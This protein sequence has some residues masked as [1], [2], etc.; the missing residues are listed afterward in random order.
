[1]P[2]QITNQA[3]WDA[4]VAQ[5]Q[6]P[7]QIMRSYTLGPGVVPRAGQT[8]AVVTTGI[9]QLTD[10]VKGILGQL[11]EVVA[12][13]PPI[14]G[15]LGWLAPVLGFLGL[16]GLAA[17]GAAAYGASQLAGVQYPWETGAGEGFIMPW[18]R[19]IVRDEA[20]QW[21]SS[22]TRPDLFGGGQAPLG[23]GQ[24]PLGPGGPTVVKSWDTG[25]TNA[26]G[27]RVAGWPFVMTSDGRI[28]T[29]KKNGIRVSYKPYKSV[30]LG[31][32]PSPRMLS[33]AVTKM[34]QF[35]KTHQKIQ[36]MARRIKT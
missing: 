14:G 16:G 6:S 3:T 22:Q 2:M 25:Y 9:N 19:D 32:N 26:E 1:M 34:I 8:T 11:G 28:H 5:G 33:R 30:V 24:A 17:G 35:D 20:G 4:L 15:G 36:K 27:Q 31:K 13:T 18:S 12:G 23:G 7:A 10:N 29:V 21:V